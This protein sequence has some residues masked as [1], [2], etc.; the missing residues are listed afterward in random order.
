MSEISPQNLVELENRYRTT[1]LIVAVQMAT[2]VILVAVGWFFVGN[3]GN[4]VSSS[5]L[6][7]LW[8]VVLFIAI[9]TFVLK[10][11]FNSWDRFKAKALLKGIPGVLAAL[12][13]NAIILSSLAEVIAVI[14]FIISFLN[15]IRADTV[16]AG[17][18]ALIV[19]SMNFP[20]KSVWKKIVTNLE[21]I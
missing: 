12:Q 16:R 15:G 10:R 3:S 18:V 8:I 4:E 1:A 20:R 11:A 17:V 5:S 6:T 2:T 19:F 7:P 9:G 21:N 13:T 14:G